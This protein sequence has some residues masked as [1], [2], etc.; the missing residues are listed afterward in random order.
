[1][2]NTWD[3]LSNTMHSTNNHIRL[4]LASF[5]LLLFMLLPLVKVSGQTSDSLQR[6]LKSA[7]RAFDN[8][9]SLKQILPLTRP[10]SNKVNLLMTISRNYYFNRPDTCLFYSSQAVEL[11]R[12]I[13]YY[14]GLSIALRTSGE[15]LRILGDYPGAL[16][17]QFESLELSRK[18]NYE[19]DVVLTMNFIGLTYVE[20]N[21]Y[22]KGLSYL[23][24]AE[25]M[26]K[27]P[28]FMKSF[29]YSNTGVAYQKLGMP[30]SFLYFQ[31]K[32][33]GV[34]MAAKDIAP[35]ALM[36]RIL[37]RMGDAFWQMGQ[38]DSA[39]NYFHRGLSNSMRSDDR[40]NVSDIQRRLGEV[41]HSL[42][43]EDSA[44]FYARL[45]FATAKLTAQKPSIM[46]SAELMKI[47]F[48]TT[49][50]FDSAFLYAD[51]AEAMEDSLYGAE[52]FRRVQMLMLAEQEGKQKALQEQQRYRDRLRYGVLLASI[53]I[54]LLVGALLFRNNRL[55]HKA[56]VKVE[57]AYAKLKDTQAQLV[58]REK[59]ASL[60][61]L[62]AGIA[63]EI[64]NPLNFV[65]NFAEVNR[66][67][68]QELH[69][70]V[71][72]G[73]KEAIR[74]LTDDI[75]ENEKK[76]SQHGKRADSIVK[77]MLL[78]SRAG[79]GIKEPT[80]INKL[81][82]EYIRLAYHGLR[83]K[84]NSFNV[85]IQ[86]NYDTS[87]GQVRVIPEDLRRVILNLSTNAFYSVTEKSRQ[88]ENGYNPTVWLTT[89]KFANKVE[90]S[91]R[92][93]GTGISSH[94]LEKIYQPF[95]TT[96]PAGHGTGLGLSITYDIITKGH[97][98]DIKVD[99][100]AGEGTEFIIQLPLE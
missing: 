1:M 81:V 43:Y 53:G 6:L 47:M 38:T 83:A 35:P 23:L 99:T 90:I 8:I 40:I 93:N 100:R 45:A 80:D 17:H 12:E 58:Q 63:H 91:V 78:H 20:F 79:S 67:L 61:E 62:T 60:G 13:Q 41:Y 37:K 76:I 25:K 4:G 21:E 57:E 29:N 18:F 11:A 75:I 56:K 22:R 24:E 39:T 49:G 16:K 51:I 87:I 74:S 44:F 33:Y 5:F 95:F 73:N 82:D 94:V 96:K 27:I 86:T 89:R 42:G 32:A 14:P 19:T 52:P 98:G 66:E 2:I 3:R 34:V 64:Q 36:S 46:E 69:D 55:K 70:E 85:T 59:M 72:K 92:D 65:N 97:G 50:N 88:A 48:R 30:D 54:L 31:K 9:D 84:D 26:G 71:G 10:D 7:P 15:M 28:F 77:G 68:L